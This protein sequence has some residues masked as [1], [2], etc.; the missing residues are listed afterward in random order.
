[1]LEKSD[2]DPRDENG[3][4]TLMP[5]SR[6]PRSSHMCHESPVRGTQLIA[7]S[8]IVTTDLRID[9]CEILTQRL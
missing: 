2:L 7:E 9:E 4:N 5:E 1:V 3:P 8:P 6:G